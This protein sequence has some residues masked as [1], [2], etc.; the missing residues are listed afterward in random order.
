MMVKK[1][2][3]PEPA[4]VPLPSEE[5]WL[6][7]AA[8][9]REND[10]LF[11]VLAELLVFSACDVLEPFP[12]TFWPA[13]VPS[14]CAAPVVVPAVT[15]AMA[16]TPALDELL[17]VAPL[18]VAVEVPTPMVN[19]CA[20]TGASAAKAMDAMPASSASLRFFMMW[21]SPTCVDQ[22]KGRWG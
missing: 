14:L 20:C 6:L 18:D 9:P 11:A 12:M 4:L 16:V 7:L 22:Q 10:A 21:K 1:V 3:E 13:A 17:V 8:R 5:L 2:P 19:C 15:P